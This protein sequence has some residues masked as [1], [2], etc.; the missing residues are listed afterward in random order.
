MFVSM[1][2]SGVVMRLISHFGPEINSKYTIVQGIAKYEQLG[3]STVNI[4][5]IAFGPKRPRLESFL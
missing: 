3:S 4:R 2:M 1:K 5:S